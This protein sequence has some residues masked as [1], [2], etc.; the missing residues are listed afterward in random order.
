LV[1]VPIEGSAQAQTELTF[2]AFYIFLED[3]T[4]TETWSEQWN[5]LYITEFILSDLFLQSAICSIYIFN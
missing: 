1:H 3:W 4:T 5:F 2:E